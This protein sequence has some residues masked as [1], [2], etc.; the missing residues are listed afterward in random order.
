MQHYNALAKPRKRRIDRLV[1][2]LEKMSM[3]EWRA[4]G[5][6][7]PYRAGI[8]WQVIKSAA[9]GEKGVGQ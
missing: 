5:E 4:L 7:L 6:V 9:E 8:P 1:L 3:T 2:E